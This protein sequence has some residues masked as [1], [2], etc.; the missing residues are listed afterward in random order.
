MQRP[1]FTGAHVIEDT[2]HAAHRAPFP[3]PE[4][5][6]AVLTGDGDERTH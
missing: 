5:C 4:A 1:L 3:E 2:Y 6:I